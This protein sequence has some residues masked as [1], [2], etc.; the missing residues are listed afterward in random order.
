MLRK[1]PSYKNRYIS[2]RIFLYFL[3]IT[4]MGTV[5]GQTVLIESGTPWRY[6]D[7]GS[8]QGTA[9]RDPGFNDSPWATGPAQLGYGDG[10]EA[11]VISYGPNPGNK[12]I[13][14]YF[15]YSF[16]VYDPS[17]PA[18]LLLRLLRDDGAVVYL[19]GNEIERSNMPSGTIN[20]LTLSSS[21]VSGGEENQFFESYETLSNLVVGTNVIAVEI[22]QRSTNSSDI[23]FD[24]QLTTASTFPDITHKAPYLIYTGVNTEMKVL[25]QLTVTDTSTIAW[26]TDISYSTGSAQTYEYG[27]DHQH[28]YTITNLIPGTKYYYRVSVNQEIHTGSFRS[29]PADDTTAIK[30]FAYGDTRSNPGVHNQVAA[31]IV[32]S[33]TEDEESQTMILASGDLVNNGN[34]ESD[35]DNQFFDPSYTHIQEML[36]SLPFQPCMGNHEGAGILFKKYFPSPFVAGR[37]WSFDYGPAHFV[38]V[39][40]YVPYGPGSAQ[41]NWIEDDL[42]TTDKPWK[43]M[44]LHEPGWSAG[45]HGNNSSVQNYIQ[46]LCEEYNVSILF[47]GHNHNYARAIVNGVQHVTTG[48]GGAP[49][50]QPN[51]SYPNIVAVSRSYH[52]CKIEINDNILSFTAMTPSGNV[53]DSFTIEN[54]EVSTAPVEDT[55]PS[56]FV[57]NPAFPN[58]FNQTTTISFSIPESNDVEMSIYNIQGQ[59]IATLVNTTLKAGYHTVSW[60]GKNDLG[61]N[62]GSG[63]YIYKLQAGIN[64]QNYKVLLLK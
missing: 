5:F 18:S 63:I 22:H 31:A 6:L 9:W 13:T 30:F 52:Y 36:A 54:P 20:Y 50:Y 11:T 8:D 41:L 37:Y 1:N 25:W 29:A 16:N 14:Y 21:T 45:S 61:Q 34:Y 60:N 58:P 3:A 57:F 7:D 48:G 64:I 19:N 32:A 47:T 46:P 24:L 35:W 40:Q 15:R 10:D 33:F 62:V 42:A 28:T 51:S 4:V 44:Y 53:I 17:Q 49:L 38:V 43:F 55:V 59:K 56:E 23:S 12:Y 27:N 26:G 39:D 2:T